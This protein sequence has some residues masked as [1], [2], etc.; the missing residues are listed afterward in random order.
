M[1]R[2]HRPIRL[3]ALAGVLATLMGPMDLPAQVAVDA[4]PGS[5][6]RTRSDLE[7]LLELYQQVLESP[8]YSDAVKRTTRTRIERIRERLDSGDFELGDRIVL[9]VQNE[10]ELPDTVTVQ[11]GP[12]ITLPLFGDI[13]L[14]GVLRSEIE[15][16]LSDALAQFIRQPVVQARAL[17]RVS[18]QGAVAQPGFYV[19]PADMLLSETLM[20]AGGPAPTSQLEEMRIDRGAQTVMEGAEVQ[21]A[22]RQ[23][24]TLDQL[25]LQ[26]GDQ[27]FL[28]AQAPGG[29]FS[30]LGV[31]VG[32][33]S[34]VTLVV[35]QL[36]R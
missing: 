17:M 9:A 11:S 21:E 15:E 30:N 7:N 8:A 36:V 24:Y 27:V 25:N 23:G 33:V 10:P 18:V 13:S 1:I 12:K 20:V 5:A 28:P 26:A 6:V 19:V 35:I 29:F 2:I 32:L 14:D 3:L 4:D 22:L 34:T 31:I 16:H